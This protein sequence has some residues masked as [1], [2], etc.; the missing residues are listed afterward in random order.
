MLSVLGCSALA[1]IILYMPGCLA[2]RAAQWHKSYFAAPIVSLFIMLLLAPLYA[3]TG[4]PCNIYS[5]V[6][7]PSILAI[8]V[9]A[10]RHVRTRRTIK[11]ALPYGPRAQFFRYVAQIAPLGLYIAFSL[12]VSLWAIRQ[13]GDPPILVE[14]YDTVFHINLAR[15]FAD[16]SSFSALHASLYL[17]ADSSSLPVNY[18]SGFYP[19]AWHFLAALLIQSTGCTLPIIVSSLSLAII[20]GLFAPGCWALLMHIFDR[21]KISVVSGSVVFVGFLVFPWHM[22][23]RGEQL[24]QLLAFALTPASLC[25]LMCLFKNSTEG[26]TTRIKLGFLFFI[27]LVVLTF[28]QPNAV[29]TVGVFTI[30]YVLHQLFRIAS[31]SKRKGIRRAFLYMACLLWIAAVGAAWLLCYKAPFLQGVVQFEWQAYTTPL[32]AIVDV[33]TG[34]LVKGYPPQIPLMA[35][36]FLGCLHIILARRSSA[37]LLPLALFASIIFIADISLEG[38]A[39]HLLSGF[40]YTDYDRTGAMLALY[41]IPLGAAGLSAI[42]Y[43]CINV[44]NKFGAKSNSH[45]NTFACSLVTGIACLLFAIINYLPCTWTFSG[46]QAAQT[47]FALFGTNLRSYSSDESPRILDSDEAC[48]AEEAMQLIPDGALVLNVPDDGSSFL[49][50]L[51]NTNAYCRRTPVADD[52]NY[53]NNDESAPGAETTQSKILRSDLYRYATDPSVQA[54]VRETGASYVLLLDK[55][56]NGHVPTVFHTYKESDWLGM[57]ILDADTPGFKLL[58]S[59]G[60]MR[61]FEIED[62]HR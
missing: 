52:S 21:D 47:S 53:A 6:I 26:R 32:H 42:I 24:P 23:E 2:L 5:L 8:A 16:T 61:L 30:F 35:L 33:L 38:T 56:E 10:I 1:L 3:L 54:A 22:L 43:A 48:F 41:E 57:T 36:V 29:F 45:G 34:S 39:K 59:R 18:Y 7:F 28:S 55:P 50:G 31:S 62:L 51:Y 49:Y 14:G 12:V 46:Q 17:G 13:L 58:L 15:A 9:I 27:S 19:A 44:L 4:T 20:A 25:L 40:W 60:D 11:N 37:W